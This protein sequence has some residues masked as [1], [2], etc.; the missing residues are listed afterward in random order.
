MIRNVP[1]PDFEQ[2][3]AQQLE[4]DPNVEIQKGV[5]FISC[6]EVRVSL[7]SEHVFILV[8]SD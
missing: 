1:Q 4:G 7:G 5:A 2:F 6:E 8:G 3:I